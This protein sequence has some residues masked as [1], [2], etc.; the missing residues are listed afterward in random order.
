MDQSS[1][2]TTICDR[3]LGRGDLPQG[4]QIRKSIFDIGS[5]GHDGFDDYREK[6]PALFGFPEQTFRRA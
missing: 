4:F 6:K 1:K 5:A 3:G 2:V